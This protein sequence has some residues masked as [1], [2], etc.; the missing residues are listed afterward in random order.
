MTIDI[1][2]GLVLLAAVGALILL[3]SLFKWGE[4]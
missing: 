1:Q 4:P 2:A 3:A